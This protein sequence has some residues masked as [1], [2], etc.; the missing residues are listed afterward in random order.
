MNSQQGFHVDP[1]LV[2]VLE[3]LQEGVWLLDVQTLRVIHANGASVQLTGY[4]AAQAKEQ[5]VEVLCAS[6]VQKAFWQDESNWQ[7]GA[8][9]FLKFAVLMARC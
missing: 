5:Y 4:T 8:N 2:S 3:G 7:G 1:L 9:F 6:L